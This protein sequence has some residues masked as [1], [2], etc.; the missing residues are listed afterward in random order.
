[1]D[2]LSPI[3]LVLLLALPLLIA[4]RVWINR[5]HKPA[6]RYSSL[7]LVRETDGGALRESLL[8]RAVTY[9]T[10][11]RSC[12]PH[13]TPPQFVIDKSTLDVG[14][15]YKCGKAPASRPS[16]FKRLPE[17]ASTVLWLLPPIGPS[18]KAARTTEEIAK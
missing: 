7:S 10:R 3:W 13:A 14:F 15:L 8:L 18:P 16:V 1:M 2:L 6:V 5:R 17:L 11:R 4:V 9:R 12:A